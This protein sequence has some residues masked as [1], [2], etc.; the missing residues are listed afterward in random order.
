M[1]FFV[2]WP[3]FGLAQPPLP[4]RICIVTSGTSTVCRRHPAGKSYPE[5]TLQGHR[6]YDMDVFI[7]TLPGFAYHQHTHSPMNIQCTSERPNKFMK[8][9]FQ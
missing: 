9:R 5:R 8:K 2:H 6:H 3:K 4:S 1:P 7:T